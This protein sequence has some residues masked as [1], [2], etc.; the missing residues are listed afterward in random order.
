M[1]LKLYGNEFSIS[2]Y[3][4]IDIIHFQARIIRYCNL[5]PSGYMS[6]LQNGGRKKYTLK[7]Y[8]ESGTLGG[9]FRI[10]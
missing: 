8:I 7:G 3:S 6:Y 1:V 4:L 10:I 2:K 5:G 9:G